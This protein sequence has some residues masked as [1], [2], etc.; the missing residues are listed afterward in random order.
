MDDL[1]VSGVIALLVLYAGIA[2][3]VYGI[4]RLLLLVVE[5]ALAGNYLVFGKLVTFIAGVILA[6]IVVGLWLRRTG[7]I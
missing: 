1:V 7:T 6:Y 3:V 2:L 5:A 4:L